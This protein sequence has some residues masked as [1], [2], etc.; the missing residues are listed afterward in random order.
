MKRGTNL[1]AGNT[2]V[3]GIWSQ[4][5][6]GCLGRGF[7]PGRVRKQGEP[8]LSPVLPRQLLQ[9]EQWGLGKQSLLGKGPG[10][11]FKPS[12]WKSES[13]SFSLKSGQGEEKGEKM[14]LLH[15]PQEGF[16]GCTHKKTLTRRLPLKCE[17]LE[18]LQNNFFNSTYHLQSCS[19]WCIGSGYSLGWSVRQM[20]MLS[21]MPTFSWRSWVKLHMPFPLI[22]RFLVTRL[23]SCIKQPET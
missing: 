5:C 4:V 3:S 1:P 15:L 18:R 10:K 6:A 2:W 8:N 19:P 12:R 22:V 17:Y 20:I 16:L 7:L 23:L 14:I 9:R 11:G 13:L 21:L